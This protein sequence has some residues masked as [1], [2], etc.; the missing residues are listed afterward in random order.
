MSHIANTH[1]VTKGFDTT[2]FDD[3]K[4]GGEPHV[5]FSDSGNE[6]NFDECADEL[7]R[8]WRDI[9]TNITG[10]NY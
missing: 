9:L 8:Y 6:I 7:Y 10:Q 5:I 2:G 4:F 1:I 3:D